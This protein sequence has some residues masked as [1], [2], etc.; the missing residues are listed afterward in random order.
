LRYSA[1]VGRDRV[2]PAIMASHGLSFFRSVLQVGDVDFLR[3][4]IA[5]SPQEQRAGGANVEIRLPK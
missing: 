4:R 3:R 5:V 2:S 1:K